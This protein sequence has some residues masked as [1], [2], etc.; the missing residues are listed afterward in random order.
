MAGILPR[1]MVDSVMIMGVAG[2]EGGDHCFGAPVTDSEETECFSGRWIGNHQYC[3]G[4]GRL[5]ADSPRR[6]VAVGF[7]IAVEIHPKELNRN[8]PLVHDDDRKIR[9]V[10]I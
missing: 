6:D 2:L 10:R 3:S 5:F 9:S 8:L 4:A 7:R 1:K